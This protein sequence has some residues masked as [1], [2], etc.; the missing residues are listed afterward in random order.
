M[1]IQT[2]IIQ[3]IT[4]QIPIAAMTIQTIQ[5]A[6][7]ILLPRMYIFHQQELNIIAYQT[8]GG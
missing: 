4:I 3:I 7:K 1:M 8:V 5:T 2:I 6:P